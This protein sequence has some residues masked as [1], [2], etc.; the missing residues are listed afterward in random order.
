MAG[1]TVEALGYRVVKQIPGDPDWAIDWAIA[2]RQ[3]AET[4]I[5]TG[6]WT[7]GADGTRTRQWMAAENQTNNPPDVQHAHGNAFPVASKHRMVSR[8]AASHRS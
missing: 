1:M 4:Q 8:S 2:A 7:G 3:G 6:G 5:F